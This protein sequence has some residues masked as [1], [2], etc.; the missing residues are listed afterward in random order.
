V[1]REQ[2]L[3][4]LNQEGRGFE[5][6]KHMMQAA[7]DFIAASLF[8]QSIAPEQAWAGSVSVYEGFVSRPGMGGA[9]STAAR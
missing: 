6:W 3:T 4:F 5:V 2:A 9:I 7:E 8:Q 1:S